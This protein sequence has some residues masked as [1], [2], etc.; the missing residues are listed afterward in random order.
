MEDYKGLKCPNP[1]CP[2]EPG[3]FKTGQQKKEKDSIQRPMTCKVCGTVFWTVQVPAGKVEIKN[4]HLAEAPVET[5][6]VTAPPET[7]TEVKPNMYT[8]IPVVEVSGQK[9]KL[10]MDED[11]VT[12][13]AVRSDFVDMRTCCYG[14]G[15]S[16]EEAVTQLLSS[17]AG[18]LTAGH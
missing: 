16:Q 11:K 9:V 2:A 6:P 14:Y 10:F 7:A 13:W 1:N 4:E 5:V 17:E 3:K 15:T 18:A 8:N 12:I